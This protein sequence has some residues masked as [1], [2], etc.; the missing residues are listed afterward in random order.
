MDR[1]AMNVDRKT[2]IIGIDLDNTII[3]YDEA[4][5]RIAAEWGLVE[6]PQGTSKARIRDKIRELPDGENHWQEAQ[7]VVYG[8]RIDDAR[9]MPGVWDFFKQCHEIN[10]KVI[11]LSH[12]TKYA[13]KDRNRVNLREAALDWL[14]RQGFL[15]PYQSPLAED[16]I[17]FFDTRQKKAEAIG[18]YQCNC[19]IDDL[20]EV[21]EN[22]SCPDEVEKLLLNGNIDFE[23][24]PRGAMRFSSWRA[25]TQYLFRRGDFNK[26]IKQFV[27]VFMDTNILR[28]ERVEGGRNSRIYRMADIN[29]IKYAVKS[30]FKSK[31]DRL[32]RREE[33]TKALAF[34]NRVADD[35]SPA[36][37]AT[38]K[39]EQLAI[40]EWIEG[41]KIAAKDIGE[42]EIDAFISFFSNLVKAGNATELPAFNRASEACFSLKEIE[43]NISIRLERLSA[44][45]SDTSL[46]TECVHFCKENLQPY[47]QER[48]AEIRK[49]H[50]NIANHTIEKEWRILSP[51]DFGFHNALRRATGQLV[52]H[53]FEYFGWDDPAKS[54]CDFWLHPAAEMQISKK[55]KERF[56]QG[57]LHLFEEDRNPLVRAR[58]YYPLFGAK[59]CCILLNEFLKGDMARRRFAEMKGQD[60]ESLEAQQLKKAQGLLQRLQSEDNTAPF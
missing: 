14:D 40:C 1:T 33:E 21:F 18:K 23:K 6:T 22:P 2:F 26:S 35:C 58:N 30:Y 47:F 45:R 31:D 24:I 50:P 13:S 27:S 57:F 4:F 49:S 41:E 54:L 28:G 59:W 5:R 37:L 43:E 60:Q 11:V 29:G 51:S 10:L 36:L 48:V 8:P 56:T 19:F 39:D 55:L 44:I 46:S 7:A 20:P 53:D 52:F 9:S 3:S 16:S 12:K 25:I 32:D 34:L 38:D 42:A 15:D 17:H